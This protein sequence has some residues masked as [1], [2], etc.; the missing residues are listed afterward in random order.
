MHDESTPRPSTVHEPEPSVTILDN[1]TSVEPKTD[2]NISNENEPIVKPTE[3]SEWLPA[4]DDGPTA[5]QGHTRAGSAGSIL[6]NRQ[7][8]ASS[9]RSRDQAQNGLARSGSVGAA[10]VGRRSLFNNRDG[11]AVN[12]SAFINGAGTVGPD[13]TPEVDSSVHARGASADAAL[14]PKQRSRIIK[15]EQKNSKKL[16][17]IIKEEGKVEKQSLSLAIAELGALQKI[18]K[19]AIKREAKCQSSHNKALTSH[20]KLEATFLDLR[21]RYEASQAVLNAGADALENARSNARD[22]TEKMQEKSQEVESLRTMLGV[23]QRER[24]VKLAE[25]SGKKVSVRRWK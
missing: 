17:K 16:T 8:A 11:D 12:G 10:S 22:T 9:L 3:S 15:S 21:T 13:A 4:I 14:S 7:S 25:L 5:T 2:N 24:E 19:A 6:K 23:D 18:Q 20:Q 1:P